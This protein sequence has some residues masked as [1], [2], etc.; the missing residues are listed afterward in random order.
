[1]SLENLVGGSY[2][3]LV[4]K[5]GHGPD[6][7]EKIIYEW[8]NGMIFMSAEETQKALLEINTMNYAELVRKIDEVLKAGRATYSEVVR[9][10]PAL[11]LQGDKLVVYL[12]LPK[13]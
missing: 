6:G 1:V 7:K 4:E 3:R 10:T 11:G 13:P 2:R 9:L 5:A 8:A 12:V